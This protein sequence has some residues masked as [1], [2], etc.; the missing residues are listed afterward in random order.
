M[1][2]VYNYEVDTNTLYSTYNF[3][4]SGNGVIAGT[5]AVFNDTGTLNGTAAVSATFLN[6]A[7][8]GLSSG[9]GRLIYDTAYNNDV[10]YLILPDRTSFAALLSGT[11]SAGSSYTVQ[12]TANG[13]EAWGPTERRLRAL[14]YI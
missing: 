4:L 8:T 7:G 10:V 2:T 3:D 9:T 13:N 6:T 11:A 5:R 14:E 1:A 12:L